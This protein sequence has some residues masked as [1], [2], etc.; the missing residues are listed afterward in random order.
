MIR[1]ASSLLLA[2]GLTTV[3]AL[4][5][6]QADDSDPL[7]ARDVVTD[8]ITVTAVEIAVQVLQNK[9]PVR[10]LEA[11]DFE[12]YDRGVLQE[13]TSF[14]V[15]D[16]T[17]EAV[18]TAREAPGVAADERARHFLILFDIDF[19]D[20]RE[21]RRVMRGVRELVGEQFHPTDRV[22]VGFYSA[23]YGIQMLTDFIADRQ[24]TMTAVEVISGMLD[25]DPAAAA[26]QLV[27]LADRTGLTFEGEA[28]GD[29]VW[30]DVARR[31]TTTAQQPMGQSPLELQEEFEVADAAMNEP[32]FWEAE[33]DPVAAAVGAAPDLFDERIVRQVREL[34]LKL[35]DLARRYADLPDPKHVI[36]LSQGFP[37]RFLLHREHTTRVLFRLEDALRAFVETGWVLQAIDVRGAPSVEETAFDGNSLFHLAES[38][39]GWLYENFNKLQVASRKMLERSSVTYLL[40]IQ[41]EVEADGSFHELEVRLKGSK[42]GKIFHRPAFRA[43]SPGE[44][45]AELRDLR[46]VTELILA[47]S[48]LAEFDM[49]VLTMPVPSIGGR[50]RVP[51]VVEVPGD[52]LL[53]NPFGDNIALE[54]HGYA[55][56]ASRGIQ[57]LFVKRLDIDLMRERKRLARG[58][59]RFVGHLELSAGTSEIRVLVRNLA[60][61]AISISR[62]PL[63]VETLGETNIVVLP[64]VFIDRSRDWVS[65]SLDETA[66]A[67]TG[68]VATLAAMGIDFFPRLQ[69]SFRRN[70]EQE[71]VVNFFFSSVESPRLFVRVLT[72]RGEE[73]GSPKIRLV[74]RW[75]GEAGGMGVLATLQGKGLEPGGYTLEVTLLDPVTGERA[76][77]SQRFRIVEPS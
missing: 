20:W 58:G 40:S 37:S 2:L 46:D 76:T 15:I 26:A 36:F 39:G 66:E 65:L 56:D 57:D 33:I 71:I 69:P 24:A 13:I 21:L 28:V 32:V 1:S 5:A 18:E 53:E 14:D 52:V 70:R 10:G 3:T 74:Q 67:R 7:A 41:P 51:V 12:V 54:V 43:P 23:F 77:S 50:A 29:D 8:E 42:K 59:L 64:P 72:A 22:A 62:V 60:D 45:L 38:T 4:A 16:L 9:K 49:D 75:E 35:G 47:D 63:E 25:R 61:D 17:E 44:R 48:D 19:T 31:W 34:G 55:L 27:E 30:L 73:I 6:P 68:E 11:S